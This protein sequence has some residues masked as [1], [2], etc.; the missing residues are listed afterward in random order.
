M[1]AVTMSTTSPSDGDP[2]I[3]G[4][5]PAD[6]TPVTLEASALD[7]TAPQYLREFKRDLIERGLAPAALTVEACFDEDCS[8]ATQKEI[9]RVRRYVR[10]GSFLGVGTVTVTIDDVAD[11]EKVRPALSATAERAER[12]GLT[13]DVAGDAS[14]EH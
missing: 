5:Q 10:A 12:D 11:P 6:V 3:E 13:L 2:A 9:D 7:S 4:C 8:L 14:L 1:Y